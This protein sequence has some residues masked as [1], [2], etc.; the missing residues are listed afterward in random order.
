VTDEIITFAEAQLTEE[1]LGVR[2]DYLVTARRTI[3]EDYGSLPN[4]LD[5]LGVTSEQ[6]DRLR[7]SL[8]A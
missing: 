7:A 4:Y 3:D 8:L 5:A 6:V 2:E 1:V